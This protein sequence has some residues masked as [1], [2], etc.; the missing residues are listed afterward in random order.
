MTFRLS[1]LTFYLAVILTGQVRDQLPF[2]LGGSAG[3][4]IRTVAVDSQGNIVV[5]GRFEGRVDFDPGSGVAERTSR[6]GS[7]GYIARYDSYG[8]FQWVVTVGGTQ[9]DLVYSVATD[10]A[11]N[12]LVAGSFQGSIV[13]EGGGANA[14]RVSRG[15]RDAFLLKLDPAGA[16]VWAVTFGDAAEDEGL[17]VAADQNGAVY[18]GGYFSGGIDI[19]PGPDRISIFSAGETDGFLIRYEA[20]GKLAW[21]YPFG[22][23]QNDRV[24]AVAVD[25]NGDVLAGG[26]FRLPVDFDAS[27]SGSRV[28]VSNG[29]AD[30]FVMKYT[31]DG[32]HVWSAGIGGPEDDL[33][34][35]IT[36][37][38]TRDVWAVGSFRG[39]ADFDPGPSL[40][41]RT[42]SGG[43]D[44]FLM[45]FNTLGDVL[46]V[47]TFGG[48]QDDAAQAVTVDRRGGALV[49][50]SFQGTV[51]FD[52]G[53]ATIALTSRG[54]GGATDAFLA[55]YVP[56]GELSWARR[57]GG[58][59]TG[60]DES[61]GAL[62]LGGDSAGNTLMGGVF[63]GSMAL[64]GTAQSF[65][66]ESA[67]GQDGFLARL[68]AD[69]GAVRLP[70]DEPAINA[71]TSAANGTTVPV[72]GLSIYTLWGNR[73]TS[74]TA[75]YPSV[76][77]PQTLCGIRVRVVD[78]AGQ[79]S[80]APLY[81]CAPGQIVWQAPANLALGS[82]QV[83]VE[84]E[85]GGAV[86]SSPITIAALSPGIFLSNNVGA[87]VVGTGSRA[88]QVVTTENPARPGECL[89]IYATG[90]GPVT[91]S[92]AAGTLVNGLY[93]VPVPVVVGLNNIVLSTDFAGLAPGGPGAYQVNVCLPNNLAAAFYDVTVRIAG[94]VSNAVRIGIAP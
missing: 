45:R 81:Y 69:G 46:T 79:N 47:V 2:R 57:F 25:R 38:D 82:G 37:S 62:A 68:D 87:V 51:D 90:L 6:G 8:R 63:A 7:D 4:N 56:T 66:L 15:G 86:A 23:I 71:V 73:M 72:V 50:G 26:V 31:P 48:P 85:A 89:L 33:L 74:S 58:A 76:P 55:R 27:E 44:S 75:T 78:G 39:T 29:G 19:D 88:G 61:T 41:A 14:N 49:G 67:G 9:D 12:I 91:P 34:S 43:T 21:G 24:T 42:S 1:F 11:N 54:T 5:A 17:A 18:F 83:I 93:R 52:P 13:F 32:G 80:F 28:I 22:N 40:L 36:T 3:D 59:N 16:F 53:L 94:L 10:G 20:D 77:L 65:V 70:S 84:T 92:I 64:P 35:A 60:S 30:A